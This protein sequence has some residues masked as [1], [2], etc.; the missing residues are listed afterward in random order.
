VNPLSRFFEW[1]TPAFCEKTAD[2]KIR[3]FESFE[4]V[5][6]SSDCAFYARASLSIS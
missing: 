6:D 5:Y 2:K 4:A 1:I 3:A